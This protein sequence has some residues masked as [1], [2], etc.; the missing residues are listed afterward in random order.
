MVFCN[1]LGFHCVS[2]TP[3]GYPKNAIEI[4]SNKYDV[5]TTKNFPIP[6]RSCD[7]IGCAC[8]TP[9]GTVKTVLI[10]DAYKIRVDNLRTVMVL[11]ARIILFNDTVKTGMVLRACIILFVDTV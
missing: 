5:D 9:G 11:D 2:N 8:N 6:A 3:V 4:L 10:S 1:T 7:C